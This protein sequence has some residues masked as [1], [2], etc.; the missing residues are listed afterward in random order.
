MPGRCC[1]QRRVQIDR[2]RIEDGDNSLDEA[3]IYVR[4]AGEDDD[5]DFAIRKK[6]GERFDVGI[7]AAVIEDHFVV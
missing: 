3:V 2:V 6:Q 5:S 4:S 1:D 7:G